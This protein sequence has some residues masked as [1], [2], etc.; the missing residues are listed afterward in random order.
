M[1]V[2]WFVVCLAVVL[3]ACGSKDSEPSKQPA[4]SE[5]PAA[6]KAT[7]NPSVSDLEFAQN[8][9]KW[10]ADKGAARDLAVDD[11]RCRKAGPPDAQPMERLAYYTKCMIQQG[12]QYNAQ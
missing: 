2:K 5:K 1:S 11:A 7:K 8:T 3:S 6:T 10:P 9:W 4:A 12:W